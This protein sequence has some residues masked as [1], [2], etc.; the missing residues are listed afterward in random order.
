MSQVRPMLVSTPRDHPV[1]VQGAE[2][3]RS[4]PGMEDSA[5]GSIDGVDERP[6]GVR[7]T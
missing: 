6:R 3:R 4:L 1:D 5:A 2:S 7:N